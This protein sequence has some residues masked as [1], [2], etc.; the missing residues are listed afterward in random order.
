MRASVFIAMVRG[1][2]VSTRKDETLVGYKLLVAQK[3]NPD[4]TPRGDPF[5]AVDTVDAGVGDRVLVTTGSSA[6]VIAER[7]KCPIDAAIVGIVDSVE[8]VAEKEV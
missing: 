2:L 6:R 3:V 7:E 8:M 5:V 1:T 4:G